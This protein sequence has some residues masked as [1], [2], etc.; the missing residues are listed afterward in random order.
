MRIAHGS[1]MDWPA[2]LRRFRRNNLLKQATLAEMLGIDQATISRWETGRIAPP[3][4]AQRR[5]RDLIG[6]HSAGDTLLR[7]WID[8]T[9]NPVVLSNGT[10]EIVAASAAYEKGHGLPPRTA[11]GRLTMPTY[12][13]ESFWIRQRAGE[14]G[15]LRGEVASVTLVARGNSLC[16]RRRNVPLKVVWTPARLDSGEILIRSERVPLREQEFAAAL[17]ENGSPARFVM[18]DDLVV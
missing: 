4:S 1:S 5:I 13:A 14:Y 9:V 2:Q 8:T 18:M 6:Y 11:A 15:F 10:Y 17:A 12:T 16:G 7:H 3:L